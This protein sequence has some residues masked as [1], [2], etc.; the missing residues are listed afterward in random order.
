MDRDDLAAMFTRVAR[1]LGEAE[2]PL[3]ARHQLSMW[4]YIVLSHLARGAVRTQLEL[5]DAI[6]YDKTRLITLLDDLETKGLITRE[7]DPA[8]RRARRVRLTSSGRQRHLAAQTDIRSMEEDVLSGLSASQRAN[9][10]AVLPRLA[11]ASGSSRA[12]PSPA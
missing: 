8:D 10:L 2:Q 11:A 9:L 7:P 3:L 12:K 5:A 1:R 6:R 4:S